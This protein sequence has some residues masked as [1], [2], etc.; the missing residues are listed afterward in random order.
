ML[1]GPT[2]SE[3]N[4]KSIS[5][6]H[7]SR[8]SVARCHQAARCFPRFRLIPP[9]GMELRSRDRCCSLLRRPAISAAAFMIRRALSVTSIS[10]VSSALLLVS[11]LPLTLCDQAASCPMREARES[12]GVEVSCVPG[13]TFDCCNGDE[14]PSPSSSD[15]EFLAKHLPSAASVL[16]STPTVPAPPDA[17]AARDRSAARDPAGT[18]PLFTLHASLL[19]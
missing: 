10:A 16:A 8:H 9:H 3:S 2:G 6:M 12:A 15:R 13:P 19:I 17:A 1:G 18:V 5:P 4:A 11:L 7:G 14:A